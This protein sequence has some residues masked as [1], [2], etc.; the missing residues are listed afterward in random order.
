MSNTSMI[1]PYVEGDGIEVESLDH[2]EHAV[3]ITMKHATTTGFGLVWEGYVQ[4]HTGECRVVVCNDD[5]V[6][7]LRARGVRP[8]PAEEPVSYKWAPD[9]TLVVR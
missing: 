8:A 5:G 4:L 3:V 9:D 6:N 2:Y 7:P 1:A